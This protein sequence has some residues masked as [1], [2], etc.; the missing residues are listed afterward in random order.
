MKRLPKMTLG[1]GYARKATRRVPMHVR[2]GWTGW[3]HKQTD[4]R[5]AAAKR[6]NRRAYR[7]RHQ[8]AAKAEA[9]A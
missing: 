5:R 4:R 3:R 9:A 1:R 6:V 8:L 2:D 7:R